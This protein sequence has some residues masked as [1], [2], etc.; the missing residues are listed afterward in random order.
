MKARR[1]NHG[2]KIQRGC[3]EI[4]E[5]AQSDSIK[6]EGR[7]L[8]LLRLQSGVVFRKN[9]FPLISGFHFE[10]KDDTENWFNI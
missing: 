2:R 5:K 10:L 3:K 6:P 9:C 4:K 7:V 1:D 8:N